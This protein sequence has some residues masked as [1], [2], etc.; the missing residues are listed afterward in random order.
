MAIIHCGSMQK[1]KI[2]T[3]NRPDFISGK[4][5]GVSHNEIKA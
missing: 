3:L 4:V 5:H 2:I 1:T